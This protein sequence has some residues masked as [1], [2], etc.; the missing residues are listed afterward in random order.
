[1]DEVPSSESASDAPYSPTSRW[2]FTRKIVWT[3]GSFAAGTAG[4]VPGVALPRP[5][6]AGQGGSVGGGVTFTRRT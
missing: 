4:N 1:M 3:L 2:R 6:T 5:G